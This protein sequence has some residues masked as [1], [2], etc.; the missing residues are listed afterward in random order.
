[1]AAVFVSYAGE[2]ALKARAVAGALEQASFDVWF[3]QRIH[4]GSEFSREIEAALKG[5]SAVVVLWSRNAIESPWVRDEAGGGRDSGRLVALVLDDC[6]PP[7]GF[8]QFQAT[9]LS[10]WSGRGRPK[11]IDQVIAAVRAKAGAPAAPLAK[12]VHSA[13][14]K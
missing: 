3:D 12:Q 8:R 14:W 11:Q 4:S 6:R 1:M 2:D 13:A 5:A 7:I 9:D 10:Q